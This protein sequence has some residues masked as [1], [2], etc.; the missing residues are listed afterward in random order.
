MAYVRFEKTK[1]LSKPETVALMRDHIDH[2]RRLA[3]VDAAVLNVKVPQEAFEG[4]LDR[5]GELLVE[6]S[7]RLASNPGA[8]PAFLAEHPLPTG[9]APLLPDDFRALCL[10]LNALKQ[11][12]AR[13]QLATDRFLLGSV[14]RA[15]CRQA[16]TTC[17]VTDEPLGPDVGLHHPVRDGRP[18]LPLRKAGHATIE[19]QMAATA[20]GGLGQALLALRRESNRSW[21]RLRRG[22]LDLLGRAPTSAASKA[23][24]A[25]AR[26]FAHAV[27]KATGASYEEILAWL[28]QRGM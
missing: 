13:E 11:W 6:E 24:Q 22:C 8:V 5:V 4:L 12:L 27:Q 2:Y 3:R 1:P 21:T 28:D 9:M 18:P 14:S 25:G 17:L 19:Q 7:R 23:S 26:S 20:D 10:V 16:A 15:V